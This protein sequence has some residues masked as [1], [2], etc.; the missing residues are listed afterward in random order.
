MD[1]RHWLGDL[2]L[3]NVAVTGKEVRRAAHYSTLEVQLGAL[4]CTAL[5]FNEEELQLEDAQPDEFTAISSCFAE[6]C[7]RYAR[8]RHANLLQFLGVFFPLDKRSVIPLVVIE[9]LEFTLG[10]CLTRFPSLPAGLKASILLDVSLGL[11]CLHSASPPV[12]HQGLNANSVFL[13]PGLQAKI[14]YP[15]ICS[16]LGEFLTPIDDMEITTAFPEFSRST[17]GDCKEDIFSFGELMIHVITQRRPRRAQSG[18]TPSL[19]HQVEHVDSTH[20]L[21]GLIMQC[22]QKNSSLR[23]S[24]DEITSEIKMVVS[25]KNF[26]NND[27][28]KMLNL[29]TQKSNLP[30][31]Q[32]KNST[33]TESKLKRLEAENS[34]L[35]AQLKITQAELRHLKVKQTIFAD[36]DSLDSEE[37]DEE[38]KK[39]VE[40]RDAAIQ[41]EILQSHHKKVCVCLC[42]CVYLSVC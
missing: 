6:E 14:T 1:L 18:Y 4:D 8:L 29:L 20:P 30:A 42:V 13:T 21:R 26:A 35:T 27:P 5:Q 32:A 40:C 31:G 37:E 23:P 16:A 17:S 2:A 3:E 15:G 33:P 41:V 39:R 11:Q 22:L 24:A 12:P 28:T 9:R 34:R 25:E 10:Q 36:T 7:H 38:P 19:I